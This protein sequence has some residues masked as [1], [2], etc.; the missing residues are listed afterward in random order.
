VFTGLSIRGVDLSFRPLTYWPQREPRQAKKKGTYDAGLD[1]AAVVKNFFGLHPHLR[2]GQDLS[3]FK[4]DEVEIG[5]LRWA[6]TVHEEVTSIRARLVGARIAYRIDDELVTPEGG[7]FKFAPKTSTLPLTLG[8]L[9]NLINEAEEWWDDELASTGL[10][11]FP[12]TAS[13]VTATEM[14]RG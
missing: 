10:V 5:R 1:R 6:Q 14:P 2:S 7:E 9:I 3:E 4:K 8:E 13:S 11:V 12:G